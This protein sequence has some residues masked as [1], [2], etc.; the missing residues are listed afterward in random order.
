MAAEDVNM[1]TLLQGNPSF[2]KNLSNFENRYT[3]LLKLASP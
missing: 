1:Q 3:H 2:K